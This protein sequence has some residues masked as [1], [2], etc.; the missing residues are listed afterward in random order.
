M[1][2]AARIN[3]NATVMRLLLFIST[4]KCYLLSPTTKQNDL[5][6][7]KHDYRVQNQ[8][9]V[10]YV[11]KIV[12]KL[13]ACIFNGRSIGVFD[14]CPASQAGGDQVSL[15]VIGNLFGELRHKVRPFRSRPHK[16]HLAFQNIQKLRYL[17]DPYF[18]Y[19][20]SDSRCAIVTL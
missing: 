19:D 8:A 5:D 16:A 10:L 12:L 14:L 2:D 6:R 4:S 18:A 7:F 17:V 13:L 9:V 11:E 20:A 15:F 1:A 3:V